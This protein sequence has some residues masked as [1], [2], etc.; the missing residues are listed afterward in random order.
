MSAPPKFV[1][2]FRQHWQCETLETHDCSGEIEMDWNSGSGG[3]C[4]RAATAA[5]HEAD[6]KLAEQADEPC[7]GPDAGCQ[8]CKSQI[9]AAIRSR[10]EEAG[11]PSAARGPAAGKS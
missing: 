2:W 7:C 8:N 3:D 10:A 9:A 11:Q 5:A 1:A 4:W 6:A